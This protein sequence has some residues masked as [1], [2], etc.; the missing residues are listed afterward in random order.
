MSEHD[1]GIDF[2]KGDTL[3]Q[4]IAAI[5]ADNEIGALIEA[6]DEDGRLKLESVEDGAHVRFEVDSNRAIPDPDE[7]GS[8]SSSSGSS[9]SG[10][11]PDITTG[12]GKDALQG[13]GTDP[14][15]V[16]E[17]GGSGG[18]PE[19]NGIQLQ[20]GIQSSASSQVEVRIESVTLDALELDESSIASVSDAET[21]AEDI[22]DALNVLF[23]RQGEVNANQRRLSS[24]VGHLSVFEDNL[25]NANANILSADMATVAT[26]RAMAEIRVNSAA[27]V[28]AQGP[29]SPDIALSLIKGERV[30]YSN[31]LEPK[32]GKDQPQFSR[33]FPTRLKQEQVLRGLFPDFTIGGT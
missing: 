21:A 33:M 19:K 8:S 25:R 9:S 15:K 11:G 6:S 28:A 22:D 7:G 4:I 30:D 31:F 26:E 27:A 12:I 29:I 16:D 10:G 3:A 5:N 2:A 17:G 20:V 24:A 32:P 18:Q 14:L 1:R 23:K 13:V